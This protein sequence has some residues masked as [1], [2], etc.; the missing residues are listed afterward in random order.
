MSYHDPCRLGRKEG[1]YEEPRRI[2]QA[3]GGEI[4]EMEKNRE[5]AACC[6]AGIRSVFRDLSLSLA[7]KALELAKTDTIVSSFCIFNLRWA[8]RKK[9]LDRKI[10]YISEIILEALR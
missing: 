9:G 1:K 5:N 3:C 6:G 10:K 2:L 4:V 7:L 8:A